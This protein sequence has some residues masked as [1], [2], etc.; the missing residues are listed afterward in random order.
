MKT[1]NIK[2][3]FAP[4]FRS[5]IEHSDAQLCYIDC[6]ATAFISWIKAEYLTSFSSHY[7]FSSLLPV[8]N[9]MFK[10]LGGK[11]VSS[12]C[13]ETILYL[14]TTIF[15]YNSYFIFHLTTQYSCLY[16]LLQW[17]C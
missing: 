10:L 9:F 13:T 2:I 15:P 1:S 8:Q 3:N 6:S 4:S 5:H 14:I 12:K 11:N 16:I 7:N 17:Y